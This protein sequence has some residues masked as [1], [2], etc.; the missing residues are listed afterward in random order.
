M[1]KTDVAAQIAD[2]IA[3]M[4]ITDAE[5]ALIARAVR[6]RRAAIQQLKLQ[7]LSVGD[8]IRFTKNVSPKYL[9]GRTATVKRITAKHVFVDGAEVGSRFRNNPMCRVFK[10]TIEVV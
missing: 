8:R 7:H 10:S 2:E 5:L 4:P 3:T 9:A 1:Q 6:Q